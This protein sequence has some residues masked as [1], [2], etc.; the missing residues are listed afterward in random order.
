MRIRTAGT[1]IGGCAALRGER[2]RT[3]VDCA[4]MLPAIALALALLLSGCAVSA[5]RG[6]ETG[7]RPLPAGAPSAPA[8]EPADFMSRLTKI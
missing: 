7:A 2:A 6:S 4:V 5:D 1:A 8:D 3:P